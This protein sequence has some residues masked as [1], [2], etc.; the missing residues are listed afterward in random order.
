MTKGQKRAILVLTPMLVAFMFWQGQKAPKTDF[1]PIQ[2]KINLSPE[3]DYKP[4]FRAPSSVPPSLQKSV[5]KSTNSGPTPVWKSSLEKTLFTQGAGQLKKADIERVDTF[6]WKIGNVDVKVDSI[7]V[8]LEH[9]KG[10]RSSFRAI[11][12]S[13]NGKILQT[14][15]QPTMDNFDQKSRNTVKID[16]RYFND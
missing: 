8:K 15:D 9:I 10:H 5:A 13:S 4:A 1:S 16:P 14:W 6:D 12:D 3:A 7:I 11:V 2:A